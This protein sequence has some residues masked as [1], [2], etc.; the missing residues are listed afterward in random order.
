MQGPS[1]DS[2]GRSGLAY[3]LDVWWDVG[4][5]PK[6]LLAVRPLIRHPAERP[7]VLVEEGTVRGTYHE[8]T[9]VLE[10][11]GSGSVVH[12]S[13]QFLEKQDEQGLGFYV[14]EGSGLEKVSVPVERV[15]S[16]GAFAQS[17]ELKGTAESG[18]EDVGGTF[19]TIW[20]D[21]GRRTV[22]ADH[23]EYADEDDPR[24]YDRFPEETRAL[25]ILVTKVMALYKEHSKL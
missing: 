7:V 25:S 4:I 16:M 22:A 14:I 13:H 12:A 17:R 18:P 3:L 19:V 1:V 8:L 23:L 2:E 20:A 11:E 15:R 10:G 24:R 9:L 6:A 5:R 21:G